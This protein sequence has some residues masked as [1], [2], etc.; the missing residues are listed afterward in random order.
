M[1]RDPGGLSGLTRAIIGCGIRVHQAF[2]PGLLESVYS[3]CM[4]HELSEAGL[5]FEVGRCVPVVY[6]GHQLK[7]RY[8]MDLL[9]EGQVILELKAVDALAEIHRRQLLTQL[10]LAELAV[11]LLMNFNVVILTERGVRRVVNPAALRGEFMEQF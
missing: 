8:Y 7:A 2:G 9:I 10:K 3:E 11:G 6:K 5:T 1:L 4:Q